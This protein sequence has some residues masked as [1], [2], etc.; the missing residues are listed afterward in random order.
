MKSASKSQSGRGP[1]LLK[2][3]WDRLDSNDLR[4]L[5]DARIGGPGQ[6][7][8]QSGD[9]DRLFLPLADE[10]CRVVLRFEGNRISVIQPGKGFDQ[11]QWALVSAEIDTQLLVG[12]IE[13]GRGI[14]FSSFRV[15]GW[16]RGR[17]SGVQIRRM[18]KN[19]PA[20][21]MEGGPHPFVLEFPLQVAPEFQIWN[22][23]RLREHR[24]LS[25][26]LNVLVRGSISTQVI[27]SEHFWAEVGWRKQPIVKFVR[28]GYAANIG[29]I[30]QPKLSKP[31][32]DQLEEI[33]PAEYY[34]MQG[35]DGKGMRV[36]ADLDE[37][38][39]RYRN[40]TP[41]DRENFD[42]A[43]YWMDVASRQ[44]TISMSASFASLVSAIE[45]LT[46]RGAIHS[47]YC[48]QCRE[49]RDHDV[50]GPTAQ[51]R[52]FFETYASGQS[53][54]KRRNDM[55]RLRSRILHGSHLIAFDEGR[56]HGWDPPW[57]EQRELHAELW[58]LSQVAL[59]SWLR[60][61]SAGLQP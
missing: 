9:D 13:V 54:K 14:S 53:L 25:L 18:P 56:A 44:W 49:H 26:L 42:R 55:Y 10:N 59:R 37:S 2:P 58:R 57:N 43:L 47:V 36:P 21:P 30:K 41:R 1:N 4:L 17:A 28:R 11:A 48:K 40:L 39:V 23:R 52:N 60:K 19:A 20:S 46:D 50:P 5:L 32:G 45:S 31:L 15:T 3:E 38:I 8:G 7:S 35:N 22:G 34:S 27:Q 24:K 6:Y 33:E 12:P 51:F 61:A 16:W 29:S